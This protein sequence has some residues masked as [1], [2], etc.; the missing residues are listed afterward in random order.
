[1]DHR[2]FCLAP[3]RLREVDLI[4]RNVDV[5]TRSNKESLSRRSR[6]GLAEINSDD[7]GEALSVIGN[8]RVAD[9]IGQH[10]QRDPIDNVLWNRD[11]HYASHALHQ[12]LVDIR[13]NET[14]YRQCSDTDDLCRENRF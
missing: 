2:L 6:I 12:Y 11:R 8:V 7:S 3:D 14:C 4:E 5:A 1:M 10:R 13:Y 9:L